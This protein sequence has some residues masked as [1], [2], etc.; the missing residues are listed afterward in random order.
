[1]TKRFKIGLC[2]ASAVLLL[3]GIAFDLLPEPHNPWLLIITGL[4][5]AARPFALIGLVAALGLLFRE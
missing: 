5:I 1:M 2:S 4:T 3:A